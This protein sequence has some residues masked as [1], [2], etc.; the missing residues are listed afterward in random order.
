MCLKN[1]SPNP[2]P[3][4]APSIIPGISAIT[5]CLSCNETTPKLGSKVV[6]G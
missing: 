3:E 5:I 4:L 6:K 1:S 2:L